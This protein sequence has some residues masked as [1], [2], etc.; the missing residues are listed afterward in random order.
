MV[1]PISTI[2]FEVSFTSFNR[3]AIFTP[4]ALYMFLG[5]GHRYLIGTDA[6]MNAV[7]Y[8]IISSLLV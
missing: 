5:F 6:T 3:F 8:S 2:F 1:P 4:K 7:F